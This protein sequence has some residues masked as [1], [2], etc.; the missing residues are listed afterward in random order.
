MTGNVWNARE[1]RLTVLPIL[2]YGGRLRHGRISAFRR[3]TRPRHRPAMSQSGTQLP[4]FA[5]QNSAR[6]LGS[7]GSDPSDI[8]THDHRSAVAIPAHRLSAQLYLCGESSFATAELRI[9]GLRHSADIQARRYRQA[10]SDRNRGPPSR[11]SGSTRHHW[12]MSPLR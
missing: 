11:N 12:R 10:Q 6:F 1:A 8:V 4:T 5:M 3:L 2:R 7:S 9:V